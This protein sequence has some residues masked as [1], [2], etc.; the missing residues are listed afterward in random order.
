MNCPRCKREVPP[1]F[2]FPVSLP[3]FGYIVTG[4]EACSLCLEEMS[5]NMRDPKAK[6]RSYRPQR[7]GTTRIGR[8]RKFNRD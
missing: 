3:G 7:C 1:G 2:L 8:G 4:M 5:Q 6:P